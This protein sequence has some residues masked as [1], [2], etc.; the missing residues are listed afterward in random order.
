MP[1]LALAASRALYQF[2]YQSAT[3]RRPQRF[4]DDV[5]RCGLFQAQLG[6]GLRQLAAIFPERQQLTQVR[7][8]RTAI[9]LPP[10]LEGR[11]ADAH[12]AADLLDANTGLGTLE[13]KRDLLFDEPDLSHDILIGL[14]KP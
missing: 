6:D 9:H 10:H 11:A 1:R 3:L 2:R 5:L 13:R 14:R 12:F 7:L 8:A 4:L